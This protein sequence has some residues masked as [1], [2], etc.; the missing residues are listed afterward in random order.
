MCIYVDICRQAKLGDVSS[1]S[2]LLLVIYAVQ[3][4]VVHLNQ[5]KGMLKLTNERGRIHNKTEGVSPTEHLGI[6][7]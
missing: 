2:L 5:Q 3:A 6:L 4:R 7:G 1:K